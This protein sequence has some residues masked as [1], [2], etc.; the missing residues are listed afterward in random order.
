MKLFSTKIVNGP[1]REK[2]AYSATLTQHS[3]PGASYG[4]FLRQDMPIFQ[5]LSKIIMNFCKLIASTGVS[6]FG[7][8]VRCSLKIGM[9]SSL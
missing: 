2:E 7:R 4:G 6:Y 9:S 8:H 5:S 1:Q 3:Q